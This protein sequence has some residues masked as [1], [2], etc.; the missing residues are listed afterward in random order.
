MENKSSQKS[1][2]KLIYTLL[3]AMLVVVV[4]VSLF[5]V[6]T[7]RR[8]AGNDTSADGTD[9]SAK[10][11]SSAPAVS[12]TVPP[13]TNP[14]NDSTSDTDKASSGRDTDKRTDETSSKPV[15]ADTDVSVSKELRYFVMPA[16]GAVSKS[17]EVD[18]PVYSLTMND[19]RAHTGVDIAAEIGSDVIAASG[20]TV[21]RIWNDPLMGRCVTIDHGDN[22]YTTY[23][24]L[25]E[26]LSPRIEVGR[27]VSLGESIGAI[28]ESALIEIAEE[29]HLHLEMKVGGVY[30]DP[31][32]YMGVMS[33]SDTQYEG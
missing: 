18:I 24:N 15:S 23:M 12:D 2:N 16:N 14:I 4:A 8:G 28:G 5:T 30:V 13:E 3:T 6:S 10:D 9:T 22:I 27:G 26:E 21:C 1:I 11:T 20:G 33:T 31:L 25:A 7:R 17:F 29:P 32:E 19:Y